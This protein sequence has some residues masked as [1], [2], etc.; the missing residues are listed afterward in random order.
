MEI[1]SRPQLQ[2]TQIADAKETMVAAVVLAAGRARRMGEG[3]PHKLLAEFD[4]IPLVRRCALAALESSAASVSVVTGHRRHEIEAKLEGLDVALVHNPDFASGMASSHSSGFASSE[5][6][7]ADGVLILF[8]DMPGISSGDMDVLITAFRRSGGH[9]IVRAVNCGKRGNPL[10][11]RARF[12]TRSCASKAISARGILLKAP[13]FRLLM[14]RL[15][16]VRI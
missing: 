4:G 15:D 14:S 2:E 3:G 8:A 10:S 9:A 1:R 11:C 12:G 5:A 16:M 6:M 13:G 7:R